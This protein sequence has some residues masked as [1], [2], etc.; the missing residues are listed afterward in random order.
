MSTE[1]QFT[2]T[3]QDWSEVYMRHS[4][5]EFKQFMDANSLSLSQVITLFRLYHGGPCGVSD[6][7]TQLGVT[8]AASSQLI[9]RLVISGLIERTED[10]IDRRAKQLTITSKGKSVLD[11]GIAARRKWMETLT[12]QLTPEQR[13]T[14]IAALTVLTTY[15]A[16]LGE[17]EQTIH[18]KH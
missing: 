18:Q 17:E 4:F 6:I 16:R 15:A 12:T 9:D 7:G 10:P 2:K 8:N 14:V 13:I 3:L 5:H 11:Q 1:T